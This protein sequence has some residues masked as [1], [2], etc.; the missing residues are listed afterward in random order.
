MHCP[1]EYSSLIVAYL[2]YY[3][4]IQDT[5]Q[6]NKTNQVKYYNIYISTTYAKC[7]CLHYNE[8]KKFISTVITPIYKQ[9]TVRMFEIDY[10]SRHELTK[11]LNDLNLSIIT[12]YDFLSL[13]RS[14]TIENTC[15]KRKL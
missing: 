6:C 14:K 10:Y 13:Q 4:S 1:T 12:K 5:V 15:T 11:Q 3:I 9:T 8:Q 2:M 7:E